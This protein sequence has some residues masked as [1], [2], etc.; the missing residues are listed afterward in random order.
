MEVF[1]ASTIYF[2]K[3]G[4]TVILLCGTFKAIHSEIIGVTRICVEE[5]CK[6]YC[7]EKH[8]LF[9]LFLFAFFILV[10]ITSSKIVRNIADT[11]ATNVTLINFFVLFHRH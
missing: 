8:E 4:A 7:E 11:K 1:F 3:R 5:I 10:L 6:Q 9:V 2:N